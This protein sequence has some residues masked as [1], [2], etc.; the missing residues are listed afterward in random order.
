MWHVVLAR[1]PCEVK[2]LLLLQFLL[3]CGLVSLSPTLLLESELTHK[4]WPLSL[5]STGTQGWTS[6][7]GLLR[8]KG[9]RCRESTQF[10]RGLITRKL[11]HHTSFIWKLHNLTSWTCV[12]APFTHQLAQLRIN[13]KKRQLLNELERKIPELSNWKLLFLPQ[14]HLCKRSTI[15]VAVM[16]N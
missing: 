12:Q 11:K 1:V 6:S 15:F 3:H 9:K 13:A 16:L 14:F 8:L 10:Y 2:D 7:Y 4:H 5:T